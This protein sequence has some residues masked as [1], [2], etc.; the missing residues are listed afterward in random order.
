MRKKILILGYGKST[1]SAISVLQK[2][3]DADICVFDEL[4]KDEMNLPQGVTQIQSVE[5]L[6][7]NELLFCLK[8]P[9]IAY[10]KDY[11]QH[12]LKKNVEIVTDVELFLSEV[13]G[14]IVAITGTNG[15]TTVT[16]LIGEVLKT[17]HK[18]VR[19]CGN[20]GIP[21]AEVC[22]NST[23][24]T[25]FVV[26]L[27][28]FQLKGTKRFKPDIAIMLNIADAHL[29]YHQTK[30]DYMASKAR[31]FSNQ[32][33]DDILIYNG[34]DKHLTELV[35]KARS[36]QL[37]LGQK[38]ECDIYINEKNIVFEKQELDI[39]V[40]KVPGVHNRYNVAY[41]YAVGV[42]LGVSQSHIEQAVQQFSGVKH[43][44]QYVTSINDIR[45]YNDSKSTN[46]YAVQTALSAFDKPLVWICGGYDRHIPYNDINEEDL[47]FVKKMV[48]Y[49]QMEKIYTEIAQRYQVEYIVCEKFEQLF[50]TAMLDAQKGE[51]VL[52]SPGAASNDLFQNFEQR[53]DAFLSLVENYSK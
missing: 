1:Q 33:A 24:E 12:L 28:S 17:E 47:K 39:D 6:N 23:K 41:A 11:V 48:I 36:C 51:I 40:I 5:S 3:A 19:V 45:I 53:G 7:T 21:I 46:E 35:A 49:G 42:L 22:A 34:D 9:G 18:D 43:R 38:K 4:Q 25:I 29:D 27:S 2:N 31:I 16:T 15:K 26:E 50:E 20:I 8:S 44:L 14:T 52:F 30:E 13:E 32:T 10:T 37:A